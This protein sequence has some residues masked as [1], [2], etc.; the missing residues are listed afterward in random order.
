MVCRAWALERRGEEGKGSQWVQ[1]GG[2]R[3]AEMGRM[4]EGEMKGGGQQGCKLL[5]TA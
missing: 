5:M 3:E 2:K 4:K 1:Q